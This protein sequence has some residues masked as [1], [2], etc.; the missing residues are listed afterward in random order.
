MILCI[1]CV[2]DSKDKITE[3]FEISDTNF[4]EST[5]DFFSVDYQEFYD[6]LSP[7]GKW[8]QVN[9]KEFGITVNESSNLES[10]LLHSLIGLKSVYA[11]ESTD[12]GINI[13]IWQPNPD[14]MPTESSEE[15]N[16]YI[17][18][19]NGEW[20]NTDAGWYFK[21][22]TPEEELTSHYGRWA[23]DEKL[24]W[25]WFPGSV[26]S[27]AWVEWKENEDYV[28]WTPL[29]PT[30]FI[31]E[32]GTINDPTIKDESKYVV[33]EKKH[34]INPPYYKYRYFYKENKNKIMIKEMEKKE[35]VMVK[36]RTII[37]KG[38]DV[39]GIEKHVGKKIE[40]VK[41]KKVKNKDEAGSKDD[42]VSVYTPT[43][44]KVKKKEKNKTTVSKPNSYKTYD[45]AKEVSDKE[46]R[47]EEKEMSKENNGKDNGQK[48]D[49]KDKGKKNK[50]EYKDKKSDDN[51]KG[52]K[53]D[54][55]D[56]GKDKGK[57]D[58]GKKNDDVDKG[59]DKGKKDNGNEKIYQH[60]SKDK[61]KGKK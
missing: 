16:E 30:T 35:G 20:L 45:D 11:Q 27:P 9:A 22:P 55:V 51:N 15:D 23:Q 60:N 48:Y 4:I 17:P 56:K 2:K 26:W 58:E 18:Y 41:I 34:I 37:N 44:K 19:T 50:D 8:I 28:A 7:H 32:D 59:K 24:G 33:I 12:E 61:E 40:K 6:A 14:L 25:V 39:T 5:D 52:K 13:F 29:P 42:V 1:S 21:A 3:T 47:K 46:N 38:P 57:K 43:L 31:K 54:D 36:N 53:N 49:D 10:S